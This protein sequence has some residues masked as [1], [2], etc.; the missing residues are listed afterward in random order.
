MCYFI[1]KKNSSKYVRGCAMVGW[2]FCL[3]ILLGCCWNSF[4]T[5]TVKHLI[6][7]AILYICTSLSLVSCLICWFVS[8]AGTMHHVQSNTV[9]EWWIVGVFGPQWEPPSSCGYNYCPQL[10]ALLSLC[11]RVWGWVI[12]SWCLL[13]PHCTY[14]GTCAI[15][16]SVH[17]LCGERGDHRMQ[18]CWAEQQ[19]CVC[20]NGE[21]SQITKYFIQERHHSRC[22]K[23]PQIG[24]GLAELLTAILT[25][26]FIGNGRRT[27]EE[28]LINSVSLV[29][30]ALG[31]KRNDIQWW[32]FEDIAPCSAWNI[33]WSGL[34]ATIAHEW[35]LTLSQS[36]L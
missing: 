16:E 36:Y 22:H 8:Q 23:A 30:Q 3:W 12:G 15:A 25:D 33:S 35:A 27:M 24:E 28:A 32:I 34:V 9:S 19:E 4:R 31:H 10:S 29:S 18:L 13:R 17:C 11:L 20:C 26:L 6:G 7:K 1:I 2:L 14:Q 5:E 21:R